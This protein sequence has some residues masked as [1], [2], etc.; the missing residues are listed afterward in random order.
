MIFSEKPIK[1][2]SVLF[3]ALTTLTTASNNLAAEELEEMI[4]TAVRMDGPLRLSTDPLK[5]RQPLPAHD[6]ADYLKTIPGFSVVRKGGTDGDAILRGM[7][8]SRISMLLDGNVILGGCSNRMDPPTAYISPETLDSIEVIKGPQSVRY[9]PG[10]SAGT[11]IFERDNN[12][13]AKAG[14]SGHAS[15]LGAS[16]DRF[17][18]MINAQYST[19]DITLRT[20]A[21]SAEANDY[22]DGDGTRIHSNYE[23]WNGQV[24]LLWTPDDDTALKVGAGFS[25]GEAAY[26]DRGV[27]GSRFQRESY[28]ASF[29]KNNIGGKW[30]NSFEIAAYD[31]YVDHVMDNYSLRTP[32]GMRS[33]RMAMNPD[34]K[35]TGAR[36]SFGLTPANSVDLLIGV[37]LQRNRHRNRSSMNQDMMDY[38]DIRRDTDARFEQAGVFSELTWQVSNNGRIFGGLRIDDWELKDRRDTISL[39]MMSTIDNPTANQ[40]QSDTLYSGFARYEFNT[41]SS[42]SYNATWYAGIGHSERF[43]D[44]WEIIAKESTDSVSALDIESEKNTQIDVGVLY[45]DDRLSGSVSLFYNEIDD[46]LLIESGYE[47]TG[48]SMD[49]AMNTTRT[50]S[51]VRNISARSWGLE[52]D[53]DYRIIEHLRLQGSL[54]SVRGANDSDDKTLP[55]LPPLEM[56]LGLN[57]DYNNWSAG[58]LWRVIAKQDRVDIGRGN[59]VGQDISTSESAD[60][61]SLNIGWRATPSLL[62]TA[63]VDNL[64]DESY[65]E[66]ISR[67]GAA[68]SGFD[69]LGRINEPGRTAWLK[70]SYNF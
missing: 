30:L 13:P 27:D 32:A 2:L 1:Q 26:A 11:V 22:K 42:D 41:H 43:P 53:F 4:I 18:G 63:G 14:L 5:P 15:V 17:D 3:T 62:L 6:G 47:K 40:T 38:R 65:A 60:V 64:L 37:D 25:D 12:R 58:I 28:S 33:Q 31:N 67:A 10:S 9:G 54:A 61:L 66:H 55:Q 19:R 59:I 8:G 49:G 23:R 36:L 29:E 68:V 46:F 7:A 20:S 44:Y 51:V 24:D 69:Q 45:R 35:T 39:S 16:A 50:T 48:M 34:R 21:S 56:R 70:M 52:L 57:Y